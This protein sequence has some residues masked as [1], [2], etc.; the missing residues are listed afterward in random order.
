MLEPTA[1]YHIKHMLPP[2]RPNIVHGIKT[3]ECSNRIFTDRRPNFIV[4]HEIGLDLKIHRRRVA[5]RSYNPNPQA[6]KYPQQLWHA[7]AAW[8]PI[9]RDRPLNGLVCTNFM[10]QLC[11]STESSRVK[12]YIFE[13]QRSDRG[14]QCGSG[15]SV[16]QAADPYLSG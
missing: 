2:E 11:W 14:F 6:D 13:L 12:H 7:C 10:I 8:N 15:T 16:H 5:G 1:V 9:E 3:R 4:G